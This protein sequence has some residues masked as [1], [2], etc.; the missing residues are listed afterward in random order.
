MTK[1]DFNIFKHGS[2]WLRA[3]FHLHT[4]A[5]GEFTYSGDENYFVAAYIQ[6][7]KK[8]GIRIGIITNHNKF[9][10]NEF[11][12]LRNNAKKEEIC[13]LPGVELSVKDG[14]HGLHVLIAFADEWIRNQEN[15]N[16]IQSFI[17]VAFAGQT[18]FDNENA[19]SNHDLIDTI[20]ELDKFERD[21]FLLYAH[22]EEQ[23]GLWGGL[24]GG[25]I[26]ELGQEE[27]FRKRSLGFHKVRT[28]DKRDNVRQWLNWYPAEMEG[29]DCKTIDEIGKG[30]ASYLKIGDF[31][32]EA[33]KYALLD[34]PNRISLAPKKH[35]RSH[36]LSASF[37]GGV[38]KGKTIYF[39]SELNTLIGIRGSGK[40]SVL[41][42]VRYALDIPFGEKT[43]DQDYKK[44]L[45]QHTSGQRRQSNDYG[46]GST[47]T[48]IRNSPDMR[49]TSGC[50]CG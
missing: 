36:I 50:L 17:D 15:K 40:S 20:R 13:L 5:D 39:S 2:A 7:M 18:N 14:S 16:Y 12:D 31:S 1:S 49:G 34:Y 30:Q 33:V 19:R 35:E 46:V 48:T 23:N 28:R 29:S 21:Y 41:E 11:R 43:L 47:R 44:N 38:L 8:A 24:S 9:D 22:V 42:A 45:I 27:I 4:K 3:D 25:R 6:G 37:E 26:Q 10:F 32:F